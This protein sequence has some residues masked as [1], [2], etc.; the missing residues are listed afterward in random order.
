[1]ASKKLVTVSGNKEIVAGLKRREEDAGKILQ[2]AA[3]AGAEIVREEISR[4]FSLRQVSGE[5]AQNFASK[6][7]KINAPGAQNV[8]VTL[9][10]GGKDKAYPFYLEFGAENRK[11]GGTLPKFGLIRKAFRQKRKE[12][13]STVLE[14][15]KKELDL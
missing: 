10:E 5:A 7:G 9:R 6:P 3:L 12:V 14:M 2:K 8:V 15:I 11:R 13:E 4:E 1:M